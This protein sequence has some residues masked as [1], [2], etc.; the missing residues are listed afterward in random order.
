MSRDIRLLEAV[1]VVESLG[2]PLGGGDVH[3]LGTVVEGVQGV[4]VRTLVRSAV[5]P[6]AQLL[7]YV[8]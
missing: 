3:G 5:R 8:M 7:E 2:E 4:T 6:A 1:E